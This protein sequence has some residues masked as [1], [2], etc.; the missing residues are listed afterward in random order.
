MGNPADSVFLPETEEQAVE[1]AVKDI[2]RAANTLCTAAD[3]APD[4][5]VIEHYVN[6]AVH[7]RDLAHNLI[8]DRPAWPHNV[9]PFMPRGRG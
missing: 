2:L 6:A 8:P 1:Y 9:I 7:L 5:A 4:G 3:M